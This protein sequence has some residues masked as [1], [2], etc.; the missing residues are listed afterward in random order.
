MRHQEVMRHAQCGRQVAHAWR[1]A[2]LVVADEGD[3]PRLVV[4]DPVVDTIAQPPRNRLGIRDERV[5]GGRIA[6]AT[7]ILEGLRQVPVVV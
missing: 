7:L 2:A 3:N 4:G 1:M 6:P 5:D